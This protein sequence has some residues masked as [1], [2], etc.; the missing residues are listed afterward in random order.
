MTLESHMYAAALGAL[1]PSLLLILQLEKQWIRE[2][3]PQCCGVLD[4][5]FWLQPDAIH[6]H[7]ECLGAFGR[8][9]NVDFYIFDL[10][11]FP[12][13]YSTAL[14]G[15]L[16][17]LW[18]NFQL[19][20]SVPV[21]AGGVDVVENVSIVKLLRLYPV[22]WKTLE[23][24]VSFLTRTKWVLV[25]SAIVFVIIG[26]FESMVKRV[27]TIYNEVASRSKNE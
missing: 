7:F 14:S 8:A 17:R 21:L 5:I 2:L 10:L 16:R 6:P 25:V 1:V 13:I 11:L 12:L 27:V 24:V 4:S 20:W 15:L 22:Q 23:S 9:M 18:P 3:P 19:V 26:V